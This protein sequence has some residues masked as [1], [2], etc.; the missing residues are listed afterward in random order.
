MDHTD[1][2]RPIKNATKEMLKGPLWAEVRALRRLHQKRLRTLKFP[3]GA[4]HVFSGRRNGLRALD[5]E[6]FELVDGYLGYLV[7]KLSA[8]P[9]VTSPYYSKHVARKLGADHS[10]LGALCN[11]TL[12]PS[13]DRGLFSHGYS[14][15]GALWNTTRNPLQ[16]VETWDLAMR[17]ENDTAPY[18]EL[19]QKGILCS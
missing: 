9:L 18:K 12:Q 1:H 2:L 11:I 13:C 19:S 14:P 17:Y 15:L 7:A 10:P 8:L 3:T 5:E 4:H 16:R 6:G